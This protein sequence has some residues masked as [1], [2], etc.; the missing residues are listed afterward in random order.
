MSD[1]MMALAPLAATGAGACMALLLGSFGGKSLRDVTHAFSLF[2][3]ALAFAAAVVALPL[4]KGNVTY[5]SDM[6]IADRMAFLLDLVILATSATTLSVFRPF[7]HEHDFYRGEISSLILFVAAGMIMVVH[8]AHFLS[9]L[10]GI[11]TMSMATYVLVAVRRRSG[12]GAEAALKYFLMGAMATGFFVY[13]LAMVY[14][15]T[16]GELAF[17]AIAKRAGE[18]GQNPLFIVGVYLVLAAI[19]FKIAAVPFHM[20]LPD[21]YEGAP[22]PVTGFMAAGIKVAAMGAL[23]RLLGSVFVH[24]QVALGHAGWVRTLSFIA[25]ATMTLANLAALRQDNLKRMLAYSS[26]AH[27]G[28][29][30]VGVLALGLGGVAAKP[31]VLFYLAAYAFTT[32][33]A[34]ALL[35]WVGKRGDERLHVDDWAGLARRRPLVAFLMTLFMLSLAGVP[36]TGGFFAK[37]YIFRAAVDRPDLVWLVIAG[38]LNSVVSVY[39]YLRIVVAMYFRDSTTNFDGYSSVATGVIVVVLAAIVLALGIVPTPVLVLVQ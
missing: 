16:G 33:G 5:F 4:A 36:P 31:S 26:I 28:Y 22:T 23:L 17:S 14:G 37:F 9:L 39:Y 10:I 29:L 35:A 38:V 20:W 30:L 1:A 12:Q 15:T 8:S 19:L 3:T 2:A 11:E 7:V 24:P 25:F 6:W 21:A 18:A 32:L 27:A 13:G 34:F